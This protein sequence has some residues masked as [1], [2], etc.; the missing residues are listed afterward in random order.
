MNPPVTLVLGTGNLGKVA[1]F[2][3]LLAACDWRLVSLG[4]FV[5]PDD[6]IGVVGSTGYSQQYH[7]HVEIR[8][9]TPGRFWNA[10]FSEVETLDRW[11]ST[12][13][14]N[15]IWLIHPENHL[16]F[17]EKL[18]AWVALQPQPTSIP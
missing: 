12:M 5:T 8:Y 6:I 17:I 4:D 3:V 2:R 11:L 14:V 7:V 13:Y 18:E 10:D 16:P 9:G 1:E 15:P